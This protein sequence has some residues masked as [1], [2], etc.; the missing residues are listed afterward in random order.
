MESCLVIIAVGI[1]GMLIAGYVF[2]FFAIR[3]MIRQ[4][5]YWDKK[6]QKAIRYE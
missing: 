5:K 4:Q 2:A 6:N 1:W 3:K